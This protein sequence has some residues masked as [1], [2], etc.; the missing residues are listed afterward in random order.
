MSINSELLGAVVDVEHLQYQSS[1][2]RS[3]S[4]P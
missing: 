3:Q 2:Y 4:P 1:F